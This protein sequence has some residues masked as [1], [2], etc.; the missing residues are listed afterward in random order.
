MPNLVPEKDLANAIAWQSSSWQVATI[1]GPAIAGWFL[2]YGLTVT[3]TA[4]AALT[5]I[6]VAM[7]ALIRTREF[8]SKREPV[9]WTSVL[10]GL[11]YIWNKK[12]VLGAISL[13]LFAVVLGGCVALYPIYADDILDVGAAGLGFIRAAPAV[14]AATMSLF[15]IMY[16]LRTRPGLTMFWAVALFGAATVGFGLATW[17][18]LTLVALFT[19]GAADMISVY[20]RQTM[21]QLATPDE[22]R[23]RVGA[24]SSVFI[25]T[26]NEFGDFRAGM[27][28]SVIGAVPAVVLG[29]VATVVVTGLWA[30]MFPELRHVERIDRKL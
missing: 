17:F 8:A 4:S 14:G 15:L 29:G 28:A 20:V 1:G 12:V 21:V 11:H 25:T 23:G 18:P 5:L 2:S 24:V 30:K 26:S 6:A 13:D 16:P 10:G 22:M 9:T 3:Y 7:T 19:M 27:V